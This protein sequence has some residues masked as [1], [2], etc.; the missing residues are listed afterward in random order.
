[1]SLSSKIA[2]RNIW[3]HKNK[4]IVIGIILFLGAFLMTLGNGIVS[5]MEKGLETN[6]KDSFT[7]D[8]VI[9]PN[10]EVTDAIFADIT[11]STR[12]IIPNYFEVEKTLKNYKEIEKMLPFAFAVNYVLN[13]DSDMTPIGVVGVDIQEFKNFYADRYIITEGEFFNKDEKGLLVGNVSRNKL[14]K[15]TDTWYSAKNVPL[16]KVNLSK[17]AKE[18][19][20]NLIIKD[21]IVLMGTGKNTSF[22]IK[23]PVTGIYRLKSLDKLFSDNLIIDINSFREANGLV[24][25]ENKVENLSKEEEKVLSEGFSFDET[26]VESNEG[27]SNLDSLEQIFKEENNYSKNIKVDSG[28][29]NVIVIKIDNKLDEKNMIKTL[30]NDFQK[31]NLEVRA[32]S[33][34]DSLGFIGKISLLIKIVLNAFIFIIFFVA[35]IVIMNTLSMTALERTSEIGMMRAIGAQKSFLKIMFVKETGILSF[36][37][38]G[39]GILFGIIVI[40]ILQALKIHSSN[41]FLQIAF[42]GD[43]LYPLIQLNDLL[44]GFFEL[45]FVTISSLLYPIRLLGKITA[46]DA[47]SRD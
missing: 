20:D 33:W 13:E 17:E 41:E 3:L 38:G 23:I 18:F 21:E 5:G 16:D 27:T 25:G 29:Y 42:G 30:N 10:S 43:Y 47:I 2:W 46:L 14:L 1:M 40:L 12:E 19:K 7:G 36:L 11:G 26:I 34:A 31:N 9:I 32:I 24:T 35:I 4:S 8:I 28:A 44:I 6:L 45:F 37:F 39:C 15:Y 22:D